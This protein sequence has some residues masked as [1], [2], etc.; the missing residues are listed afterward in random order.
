MQSE[1]DLITFEVNEV[2]FMPEGHWGQKGVL[3]VAAS[4]LSLAL[5]IWVVAV[6]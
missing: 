2:G 5:Q 3:A 4:C 1:A 6:S